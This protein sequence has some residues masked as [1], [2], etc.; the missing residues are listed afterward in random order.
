LVVEWSVH[1]LVVEGLM[2]LLVVGWSVLPLVV[3]WSVHQLG[4]GWSVRQL[5]LW[6][7]GASVGCCKV[8]VPVGL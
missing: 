5:V 7:I 8:V 2:Y 1:P 3:W 6:G 4:V